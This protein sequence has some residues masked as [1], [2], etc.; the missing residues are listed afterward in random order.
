MSP[1][2]RHY[3]TRLSLC[4]GIL[5]EIQYDKEGHQNQAYQ[6]V[7]ANLS[8]IEITDFIQQ[9]NPRVAFKI[10]TSL[11]ITHNKRNI[12]VYQSAILHFIQ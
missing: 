5:N 9:F 2:S 10:A 1:Q 11:K 7:D 3:T 4:L 6:G 12:W 8:P